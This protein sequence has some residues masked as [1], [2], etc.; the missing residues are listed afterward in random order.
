MSN[1]FSRVCSCLT[2]DVLPYLRQL[3]AYYLGNR[4]SLSNCLARKSSAEST[5]VAFPSL[6]DWDLRLGFCL[7]VSSW[8]FPSNLPGIPNPTPPWWL[9]LRSPRP[10]RPRTGMADKSH[11]GIGSTIQPLRAH[12][13]LARGSKGQDST[14]RQGSWPALTHAPMFYPGP[15][16]ILQVPDHQALGTTP[17]NTPLQKINTRATAYTIFEH[18]LCAVNRAPATDRPSTRFLIHPGTPR[19]VVLSSGAQVTQ[20][21]QDGLSKRLG[22]RLPRRIKS[23]ISIDPGIP[24]IPAKRHSK[25]GRQ[26]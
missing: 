16:N 11:T 20:A 18:V 19:G 7:I 14:P 6:L 8:P 9:N 2:T 15:G 5:G 26:V 13:L 12:G 21:R 25:R 4:L 1:R 17:Q 22:S 10:E 3:H 24:R 23:R